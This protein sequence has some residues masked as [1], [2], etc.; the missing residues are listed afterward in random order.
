MK[1]T[2]ALFLLSIGAL[3]AQT[4]VVTGIVNNYSGINVGSV[5]QGAI[6]IVIGTG[7]ADTQTTTLQSVPLQTTLG[8]V[9]IEI[10]VAGTTTSAPLYYALNTQLA[11]ILP[12]NT[13]TGTGTLTVRNN[14]KLSASVPITVVKSAFGALTTTGS[15]AARV[16]DASQGYQELSATRATNPGNVLVFYGS[17]VGP[18]TGNETVAQT[19]TDLTAIPISVTIGGKAAQVFYRGRTVFPGLDQINVAV[20]ALDPSSYGCNVAV[21]IRTN[22]VL[23]NSITI[24]VAAT[25][26]TCPAPSGGG[27][28]SSDTNPT[29]AEISLWSARGSYTQGSISMNRTTSYQTGAAVKTDT[30]GAIFNSIVGQSIGPMLRGEVPSDLPRLTPVAGSCVVYLSTSLR[31]PYP[32]LVY[33]N[34]DAGAQISVTGPNGARTI[35]RLTNQVAG[36][37]YGTGQALANTYLS[38]GSYA[39]TG[40]GGTAVGAF[41]GSINVVNDLVVTNASDFVTSINRNAPLTVRWTGGDPDKYLTVQG[42]SYT[43]P[44]AT[45]LATTFTCIEKVSAGQFTVPANF[46]AQLPATPAG[47]LLPGGFSVTAPGTGARFNAPTGLDILTANNYWSWLFYPQWQ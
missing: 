47:Y 7:L 2:L 30:A 19:Q 34:L 35:P 38:P 9:R 27:G 14:S 41:S 45:V 23:A 20:P 37:T 22:D 21:T 10:T 8:N 43:G 17:G 39:F 42:V 33:T 44:L 4:P 16:Q 40:P 28:A 5:A 46:V 15:S 36:P 13:P 25:G 11:G 24:P 3:F 1:R 29:P 12:S 18:V 32:D 31:N 6:F 26:T